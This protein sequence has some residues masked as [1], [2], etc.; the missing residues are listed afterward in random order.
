VIQANHNAQYAD[1][2][3]LFIRGG[4]L[5]GSLLAQ[6]F[7]ASR[8]A[9]SGEAV[10]LAEQVS[11]YGAYLGMGDYS[12]SREGTLIFDA[13]RLQTRSRVR[14][15]GSDRHL[16]NR[17]LTSTPISPTGRIAFDLTRRGPRRPGVGRRRRA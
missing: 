4:D 3:L 6:P 14:R 15:T 16:R 1:G 13:F 5:G 8:L 7:D 9:T 10:T 17:P 11:L 12:V 2:F